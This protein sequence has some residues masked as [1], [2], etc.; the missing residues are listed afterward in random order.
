[1]SRIPTIESYSK[2]LTF[3]VLRTCKPKG[4][5]QASLQGGHS[6]IPLGGRQKGLKSMGEKNC[7]LLEKWDHAPPS[8]S[9]HDDKESMG[10]ARLLRSAEASVGRVQRDIMTVV[11]IG[12]IRGCIAS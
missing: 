2:N 9:A 10:L 6:K 1:M 8:R 7:R 5:A 11:P 3:Q 4:V 12:K